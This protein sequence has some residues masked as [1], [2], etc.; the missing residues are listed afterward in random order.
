ML[1]EQDPTLQKLPHVS[2]QEPTTHKTRQDINRNKQHTTKIK[3]PNE[4]TFHISGPNT[5]ESLLS[6]R[7]SETKLE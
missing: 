4:L 6:R 3:T 7:R 2:S 1:L 5:K